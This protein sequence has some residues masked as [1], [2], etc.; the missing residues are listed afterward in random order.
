MTNPSEQDTAHVADETLSARKNEEAA[1]TATARDLRQIADNWDS[2]QNELE[3][4][5]DRNQLLWALLSTEIT[6]NKTLPDDV[7]QNLL[8]LAL[9]VFQKSLV[10]ITEPTREGVMSLVNIN[11]VLAQGLSE[12]N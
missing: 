10:M 4:P 8:N 9:F 12:N 2:M 3:G 7:R 5:L 6:E 11:M 1:L